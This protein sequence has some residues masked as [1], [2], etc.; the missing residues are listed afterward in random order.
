MRPTKAP[1][2]TYFPLAQIVSL[3]DKGARRVCTWSDSLSYIVRLHA[4]NSKL[5]GCTTSVLSG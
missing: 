1:A 4:L 2:R 3:I 5:H